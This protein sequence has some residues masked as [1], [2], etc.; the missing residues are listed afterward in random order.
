M[1]EEMR[2]QNVS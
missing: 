2:L 1:T